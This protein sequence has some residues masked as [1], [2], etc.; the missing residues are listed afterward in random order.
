[1]KKIFLFLI[2]MGITPLLFGQMVF[3]TGSWA[4]VKA[5]ALKENKL[6]FVDMYT[7]WCGPCKIMVNNIFPL[8]Q[9]GDFYNKNFVL[10]KI[11]AE[12]GE[13]VAIAKE[14]GVNSFPTYLFVDGTGKLFYRSGGSMPVEKFIKEGEKALV[15]FADK[16]PIEEWDAEYLK[17]KKDPAFVKEY[18]T[19]RELLKLDNSDILD[20]Y[21]KIAKPEEILNKEFLKNV[22]SNNGKINAGGPFFNFMMD[23]FEKLPEV[24]GMS[25]QM[26]VYNMPFLTTLYSINKAAKNNDEKFFAQIL[27]GNKRLAALSNDTMSE[28][29]LKSVYF[30]KT[31]QGARLAEIAQAYADALIASVPEALEKDKVSWDKYLNGISEK[32]EQL[33]GKTAADLAMSFSFMRTNQASGLSYRIRDLS[34]AVSTLCDNKDLKYKALEWAYTATLLFEN[35]SN[36]EA[37]AVAYYQLGNK[38][39]GKYWLERCKAIIPPQAPDDIKDRV[40]SR[41]R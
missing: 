23:H 40:N 3:E 8:P 32:P 16:K 18:I 21:V 11:D 35:F 4:D 14:Y 26:L 1:M 30:N 34:L 19:K 27:E 6:I 31:K 20:V 12:K 15:Q 25:R 17:K 10:Y 7:S 38:K 2:L 41:E 37:I 5:K 28:F 9:S 29:H 13:G 39:D 33:K 24:S 36:Y 22:I